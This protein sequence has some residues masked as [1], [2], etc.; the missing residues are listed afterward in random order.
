MRVHR[1]RGRARGLR[2]KALARARR[3]SGTLSC[4][5]CGRVEFVELG[6]VAEAEFEAHHR[7]PL[8]DS[9]DASRK[10]RVDDLAVLCA[11]CHRVIHA[12]MRLQKRAVSVEELASMMAAR[13]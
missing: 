11:G 3:R 8:A 13:R 7:S 6:A 5:G 1:R 4:E 9:G 2:A 10:A 12:A